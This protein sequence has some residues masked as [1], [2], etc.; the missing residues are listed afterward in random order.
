MDEF[1][2]DFAAAETP[3]SR[4]RLARDCAFQP[5]FNSR[6]QSAARKAP[7]ASAWLQSLPVRA[8]SH[9]PP[10]VLR[11]MQL[12]AESDPSSV[13]NDLEAME[14]KLEFVPLGIDDRQHPA[15][16]RAAQRLRVLRR[17]QQDD[18]VVG[19]YGLILNDLKR[20]WDVVDAFVTYATRRQQ[21]V[22][23]PRRI[24]FFLVGKVIDVKLFERIRC[25]FAEAGLADRLVHSNPQQECDFDA[26][27][28]ACDAVMCFRVQTRGQFSHVFVRALSLGTPVMVNER[29]G[30]A[31][32]PRTTIADEDVPAGVAAALDRL[33]DGDQLADMRRRARQEYE[34]SHRGD[35]SLRAILYPEAV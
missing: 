26:E 18:I 35:T 30:Y 20:L 4:T 34:V 24:F 8:V 6:N 33:F 21:N 16:A 2:L 7:I 13:I 28:A 32:D 31:Y 5:M 27:I 3:E 17:V 22:R 15:V 19:H 25:A 10:A 23:N 9:L 11:Q 1:L 29:S 12:Q 14:R